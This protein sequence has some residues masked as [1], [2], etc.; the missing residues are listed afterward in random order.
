MHKIILDFPLMQI[1]FYKY[2]SLL[3]TLMMIPSSEC[4]P[5]LLKCS[6]FVLFVCIQFCC[7]QFSFCLSRQNKSVFFFLSCTWFPVCV[8]V[9]CVSCDVWCVSVAFDKGTGWIASTLKPSTWPQRSTGN[10]NAS[11][12]FLL[13]KYLP[14]A[15]KNPY[16]SPF[17]VPRCEDA[18]YQPAQAGMRRNSLALTLSF[19]SFS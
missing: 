10:L 11:F 15:G 19:F 4:L 1:G 6:V 13:W 5:S 7:M 9:W 18:L 16:T 12:P 8:C 2:Y 3:C 14:L 17:F